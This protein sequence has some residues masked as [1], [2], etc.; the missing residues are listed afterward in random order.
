MDT[1]A[2]AR[3]GDLKMSDSPPNFEL[4]LDSPSGPPCPPC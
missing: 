4:E 3:Q 2:L 1:A